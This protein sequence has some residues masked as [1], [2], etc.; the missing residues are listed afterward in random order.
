MQGES[1]ETLILCEHDPVITIGRSAKAGNLLASPEDLAKLGIEAIEIERG[2][3]ITYH[4]PGQ[5]VAYP[6]LNL[7]NHRRDVGWYLR[8]LEDVV[9]DTL[10]AFGIT[11]LRYPGR[12]GVWTQVPEN[13]I[14]FELLERSA[15]RSSQGR[16]RKIASIG[17]R[18]SRWCTLHGLALNV[19]DCRVGFQCIN[20]CGFTDIDVTSM[21]EER[22]SERFAVATVADVL[23]DRFQERFSLTS[24]VDEVRDGEE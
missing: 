12:T 13:A 21:A 16:P 19:H 14:N 1:E 6:L 4:G 8:L 18:L 24:D 7:N 22:P 15:Q 23:R 11:G 20:P 2:G 17:V 10:Q 5:L 3:D 9:I